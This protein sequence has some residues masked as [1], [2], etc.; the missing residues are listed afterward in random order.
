MPSKKRVEDQSMPKAASAVKVNKTTKHTK[1]IMGNQDPK[2]VSPA[3]A[4]KETADTS[5]VF[6][7]YANKKFKFDNEDKGRSFKTP[8]LTAFVKFGDPAADGQVIKRKKKKPGNTMTMKVATFAGW[9]F[10]LVFDHKW[11]AKKLGDLLALMVYENLND[12]GVKIKDWDDKAQRNVSRNPTSEEIALVQ[13]CEKI[14]LLPRTYDLWQDG[15]KVLQKTNKDIQQN[16]YA[17]RV[18]LWKYPYA[19]LDQ[20]E[21]KQLMESALENIF[22]NIPTLEDYIKHSITEESLN[23]LPNAHLSDVMTESDCKKVFYVE[24]LDGDKMESILAY[25]A[26]QKILHCIFRPGT[27]SYDLAEEMYATDPKFVLSPDAWRAMVLDM[28][29]ALCEPPFNYAKEDIE[30]FIPNQ[31]K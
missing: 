13:A 17:E 21:K 19:D 12:P 16:A 27:W 28:G 20:K 30:S 22:N 7:P 4:E 2:L 9:G 8:D 29:Y 6:N 26:Y 14:G 10:A 15:H 5:K 25:K 24:H 1:P 23:W 3:K 11:A 18:F 31:E